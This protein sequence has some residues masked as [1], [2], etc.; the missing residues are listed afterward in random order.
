MH[1]FLHP[2]IR[3]PSN[4]LEKNPGRVP[5]C[6]LDDGKDITQLAYE[7]QSYAW[8]NLDKFFHPF[9]GFGTKRVINT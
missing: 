2:Q 7:D 8:V 3:R 9:L 4:D 1:I 5:G 6:H